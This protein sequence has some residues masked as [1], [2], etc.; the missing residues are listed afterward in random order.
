MGPYARVK[1]QYKDV[2]GEDRD[3]NPYLYADNTMHP[4]L[5]GETVASKSSRM[6]ESLEKSLRT[7][8]RF[9]EDE[10]DYEEKPGAKE[11][12]A[13]QNGNADGGARLRAH[14]DSTS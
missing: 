3:K 11:Q 12:S 6:E 7:K 8:E 14:V 4:V 13:V 1:R 9:E 5:Y 10:E 2:F